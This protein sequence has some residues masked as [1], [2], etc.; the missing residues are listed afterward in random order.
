MGSMEHVPHA[1]SIR[2]KTL[3]CRANSLYENVAVRHLAQQAKYHPCYLAAA[4]TFHKRV[5]MWSQDT[6]RR[7]CKKKTIIVTSA[8]ESR[9]P[10]FEHFDGL[11]RIC[12]QCVNGFVG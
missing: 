6:P 11:L 9:E 8:G 1:Q 12:S 4:G 7:V 3:H 2:Q 10:H 5:T